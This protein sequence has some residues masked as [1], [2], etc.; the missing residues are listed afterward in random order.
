[1][2]DFCK[3]SDF[4]MLWLSSQTIDLIIMQYFEFNAYVLRFRPKWSKSVF[5][6]ALT[7]LIRNLFRWV[8]NRMGMYG[9][10]ERVG[11]E[12]GKCTVTHCCNEYSNM[13][14]VQ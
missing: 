2:T 5:N 10:Q 4:E 1:M 9:I 8:L 14:Y 7:P 3:P 11:L 13:L 6:V 12:A